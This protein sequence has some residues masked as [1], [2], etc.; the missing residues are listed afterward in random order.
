M[1]KI[2][3]I[4]SHFYSGGDVLY[5]TLCANSWIQGY[6][7]TK[8]ENYYLSN[9]DLLNLTKN[10]HK[11]ANKLAIYLDE[12]L[13]NQI[14]NPRLDFSKCL[15]IGM[16]RRPRETLNLMVQESKIK[17]IF[18]IRYYAYRLKRI[19][20]IAKNSPNC[21]LLT[22]DNLKEEKGFD[23]IESILRLKEKSKFKKE[24]LGPL[25]KRFSKD[26]LPFEMIKDMEDCYE[27]YYHIM[28][29]QK[30]VMFVN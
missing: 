17:P 24:L 8:G 15:V 5:Q 26:L 28:T 10:K 20:Q 16:I 14:L 4:N 19:C 18:A 13:Q 3:F 23:L 25:N 1:K 27:K 29:Q 2:V 7:K 11:K 12:I 30:N 22:Y 9:L 6:K 21:L